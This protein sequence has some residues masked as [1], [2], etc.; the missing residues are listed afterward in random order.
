MDIILYEI[1][2]FF[3]TKELYLTIYNSV[4]RE[5]IMNINNDLNHY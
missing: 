1:G 4:L 2:Y 5:E 3:N